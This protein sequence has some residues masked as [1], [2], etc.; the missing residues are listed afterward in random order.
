MKRLILMFLV[1]VTVLIFFGCQQESA[2]APELGQSDQV[3]AS[4][5]KP[6]ANLIGTTY[7]PFHIS[8]RLDPG[9][10][11]LPIFWEGTIDFGEGPYGLYASAM[12]NQEVIH[13]QVL[14]M[15]TL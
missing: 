15:K 1:I 4:L 7:T 14:S 6:T 13:K 3:P 10:S 2:L 11:G 12:E 5:A 8:P 9:G